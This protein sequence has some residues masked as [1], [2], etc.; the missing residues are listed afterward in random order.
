[1]SFLH[2][3]KKT[4]ILEKQLTIRQSG[5]QCNPRLKGGGGSSGGGSWCCD[6]SQDYGI[7][8]GFYGEGYFGRKSDVCSGTT[9]DYSFGSSRGGGG[10]SCGSSV[11]SSR[12]YDESQD[13]CTS[14]GLWS[15]RGSGGGSSSSGP[16]ISDHCELA[17][18]SGTQQSSVCPV[19]L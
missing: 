2:K 1:M 13:Y 12:C 19:R 18:D 3:N 14:G 17:L 5:L 11:S 9:S 7:S 16:V 4:N 6:E 10:G 8:G 15:S